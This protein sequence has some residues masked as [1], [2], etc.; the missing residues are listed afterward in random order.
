MGATVTS[1]FRSF[2]LLAWRSVLVYALLLC[3]LT[4]LWWTL[5]PL[6]YEAG[7]IIFDIGNPNASHMNAVST[8]TGGIVAWV[9]YALLLARITYKAAR[10]VDQAPYLHGL[11]ISAIA[12]AGLHIIMQIRWPEHLVAE[13]LAYVFASLPGA[14]VGGS[15]ASRDIH[16]LTIKHR[17][18][19]QLTR[20]KSAED[21]PSAFAEAFGPERL[22][23]IAIY[24]FFSPDSYTRILQA[25][26]ADGSHAAGVKELWAS[27]SL[28]EHTHWVP[29][30]NLD[31]DLLRELALDTQ[32]YSERYDTVSSPVQL[33]R[34]EVP[35]TEKKM[36]DR[37]RTRSAI[38][39]GLWS[40]HDQL[41]GA[42]LL[43]TPTSRRYSHA[44]RLAHATLSG[45]VALVLEAMVRDEYA[46]LQTIMTERDRLH[47]DVHD[48]FINSFMTVLLHAQQLTHTV[49][50]ST[51]QSQQI[52]EKLSKLANDAI[53]HARILMH[54]L[55]LSP[56][57]SASLR[58]GID[59]IISHHDIES[60]P[61][62]RASEE[63]EPLDIALKPHTDI[64]A[65]LN[66][67]L[68][69][70]REHAGADNVDI[71]INYSGLDDLSQAP[72]I[73][74]TIADDGE[75]FEPNAARP[76]TA[77]DNSGHGLANMRKRIEKHGG[78]VDIASASAKGTIITFYLPLEN[79]GSTTAE[80]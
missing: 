20:A 65:A 51:V 10:R 73:T 79:V 75:G 35:D 12:V 46:R 34:R 17:A 9:V 3:A 49:S 8:W 24:L 41:M 28:P 37:T 19:Q 33:K 40:R 60:S 66:E 44:F 42:V 32:Q 25:H 6:V 52:L 48:W 59:K 23:G 1:I 26:N 80:Q 7:W 77:A 21:I 63:G 47:S 22:T 39:M 74:I 43:T 5:S 61:R 57:S 78:T 38:V 56:S 45:D 50:T 72:C 30:D 54:L 58:A 18:K 64:L 53:A 15:I 29:G 31:L 67:A 27:W 4:V 16:T 71:T 14:A 55:E 70:S 11:V 2:S 69:N 13:S 36:W 62:I 76:Q 68:S